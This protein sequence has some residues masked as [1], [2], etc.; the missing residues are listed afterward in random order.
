MLLVGCGGGGDVPAALLIM[1]SGGASYGANIA[2]KDIGPT[3]KDKVIRFKTNP[4]DMISG[5]VTRYGDRGSVYVRLDV[6]GYPIF[7][8]TANDGNHSVNVVVRVPDGYV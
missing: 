5:T 1:T 3:G 2:G 8:D 6:A 7:E 4:G